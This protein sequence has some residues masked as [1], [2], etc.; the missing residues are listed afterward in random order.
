MSIFFPACGVAFAAFRVWLTVRIVNRRERWAKWMAGALIVAAIAGYPLSIGPVAVF[1]PVLRI[2]ADEF[3]CFY[4]PIYWASYRSELVDDFVFG[5]Y[6]DDV[7]QDRFVS[8][9]LKCFG[10]DE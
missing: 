1:A 3:Y 4:Y 9:W 8:I 10:A 7:W 5:W 6:C 2:R